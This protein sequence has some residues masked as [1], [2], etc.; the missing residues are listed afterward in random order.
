MS[1]EKNKAHGLP[2]VGLC[3]DHSSLIT[4]HSSLTPHD[5]SSLIGSRSSRMYIGRPLLLGNVSDGSMPTA[6]YRVLSSCGAVT[7]R[8]RGYSPRALDEPMAWPMR[9]PPPAT[10]ADITGAQW[11]RPAPPLIR[12]VRP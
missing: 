2:P 11:S 5:T 9:R 1:D 7:R 8:S 3:F 4:H 12:G 6:R 10:R